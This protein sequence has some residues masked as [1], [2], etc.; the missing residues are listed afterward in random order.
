MLHVHQVEELIELTGAL[1][2]SE[3]VNR[4]L[5]FRATFPLDFTREFLES[6]SLDRLR[7]LYVALCLHA[8]RAPDAPANA[9]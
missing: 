5:T 3:L 7:H 6:Q 4:F 2:K 1:E 8:Q 9:A